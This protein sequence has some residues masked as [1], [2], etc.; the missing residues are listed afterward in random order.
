MQDIEFT[1]Q[2]GKLWLLQTRSGKRTAKAMVKIAV[3]LV[4]DGIISKDEAILRIEPDKLDE[5]LHP[6]FDPDAERDVIAYG[7]AASPGA[8]VGKVVFHAD[9]A[10]AAAESGE[11]VI[12]VRLE[13]SPEDIHGMKAAAGILTARG[14]MTSHAAVVAR[15]MGRCCV[16]GCGDLHID[17]LGNQFSV[18]L[19][20]REVTI[21]RGETISI[22]GSTGEVMLGSV[23]V[24]EGRVD[25]D[26][27]TLMGWVDD[28]RRLG[29][30]A[31]ADSPRDAE[32]ALKYGAEG[33]GLCRT[34]HMFFEPQRILAVREMILSG[35]EEG[36][37]VALKKILPMQ[38]EDFV[39]M[40]RV[41]NGLPLT[42]RLLD[43]PLHE[44]LPKTDEEIRQVAADLGYEA[45]AVAFRLQELDEYNP[46]LGH[47]GTR[48]GVT[49]PEIYETQVRAII[50][51][52]CE[53]SGEG[54]KAI[55][56]IMI[57]IVAVETE[58]HRMRKL[59]IET[60]ETVLK[61]RG[62]EVEYSGLSPCS[63]TWS[64]ACC[65]SGWVPI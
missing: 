30:R 5:L 43:P 40:F 12:L 56:E 45:G 23:P 52:A 50:E 15:G 46:M 38:R 48:L 33:V 11:K 54:V 1:I 49:Y 44:F 29:V 60:A 6:S 51:A 64:S 63:A 61:E 62:V 35:D 37:R 16:S 24:V 65:S 10:V 21:H 8:A 47:R 22:D 59:A 2:Q 20:D 42:I 14:G 26:Y 7:L 17:Y 39:S 53:V 9:D 13:T 55:A 57:P 41:M 28:A 31:N 19:D 34:E 25:Q 4:N 18:T 58:L 32:V 27:A 36:R 3:D